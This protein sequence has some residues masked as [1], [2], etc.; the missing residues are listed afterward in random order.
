MGTEAESSWCLTAR[1]LF[2]VLSGPSGVGK[3]AVLARLKQSGYPL[4]YIVTVTTRPKRPQERDNLDYH[5]I[6]ADEFQ[7]MIE[8]KE[9]LEWAKVYG[10]WYGVPRKPVEQAL[11]GGRDAM[12]KVDVQGAASIRKAMPQ[13]V[14][15]FLVP[16]SIA[17]LTE[18]LRQR[19]T[20]SP[21]DLALRNHVATEEIKQLSLFDYVVVN[22]R[23]EID[24]AV[25]DIE[26]IIKA[27]KRRVNPR[28]YR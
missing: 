22:K 21:A 13:A 3:D 1:P 5:F 28:D 12:V 23:D 6:P 10:N 2:F 14:L 8:R 27:E 15:I 19:C 25:S 26:A 4:E 7:G 17:E 24:R 16:E 18:R 11:A 9:L 20:E